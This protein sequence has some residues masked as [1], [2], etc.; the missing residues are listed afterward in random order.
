MQL[1]YQAPKE[2]PQVPIFRH[3]PFSPIKQV[4]NISLVPFGFSFKTNWYCNPPSHEKALHPVGGCILEVPPSFLWEQWQICMWGTCSM[5]PLS[6]DIKREDLSS[7]YKLFSVPVLPWDDILY[8]VCYMWIYLRVVLMWQYLK[9]TQQ[10]GPIKHFDLLQAY[11][12]SVCSCW[13]CILSSSCLL[14]WTDL[15]LLICRNLL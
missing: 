10:C 14:F 8:F 4:C 7:N 6:W 12:W 13:S 3:N 5:Q 9:L 2:I 1:F 11:F 15:E